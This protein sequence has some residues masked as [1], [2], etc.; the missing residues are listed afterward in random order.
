[1]HAAAVWLC[2]FAL[3]WLGIQRVAE[4]FVAWYSGAEPPP[5]RAVVVR[6]VAE[7]LF[8]AACAVTAIATLQPD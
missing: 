6:T 4:L 1:M 7:V 8:S 5:P 3:F 2:G